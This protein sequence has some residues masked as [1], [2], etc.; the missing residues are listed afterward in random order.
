MLRRLSY[1][2]VKYKHYCLIFDMVRNV[3][4]ESELVKE[5]KLSFT[6]FIVTLTSW[7]TILERHCAR[8][9]RYQ[10]NELIHLPTWWFRKKMR[11]WTSYNH[12]LRMCSHDELCSIAGNDRKQVVPPKLFG[13]TIP[14]SKSVNSNKTLRYV[15]MMI[16]ISFLLLKSIGKENLSQKS[17]Q[18]NTLYNIP[19]VT[20]FSLQRNKLSLASQYFGT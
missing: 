20:A 19:M 10:W 13:G 18:M 16:R 8:K 7:Q 15:S 2:Q 3:E 5:D 9:Y 12:S 17:T 4:P 11:K 6:F 14:A 1:F